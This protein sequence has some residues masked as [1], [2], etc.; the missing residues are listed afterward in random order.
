MNQGQERIV[1]TQ[2]IVFWGYGKHVGNNT[3]SIL[4]LKFSS[5]PESF[6]LLSFFSST[7]SSEEKLFSTL[8]IH[9]IST[10]SI[11]T[12]TPPT[13]PFFFLLLPLL[14]LFCLGG[15]EKVLFRNS[16][17]FCSSK[18]E[19]YFCFSRKKTICG[20]MNRAWADN[21]C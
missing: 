1:S 11:S 10:A 2:S 19:V 3:L 12:I 20:C 5:P 17:S 16:R 8:Q 6:F 9:L 13:S 18:N 21:G 7:A 14:L 4:F 15:G